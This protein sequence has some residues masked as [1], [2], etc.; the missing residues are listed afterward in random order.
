MIKSTP[1]QTQ[2]I[3]VAFMN[4]S[5]D[6]QDS[7]RDKFDHG[8]FFLDDL[9]IRNINEFRSKRHLKTEKQ[10]FPLVTPITLIA[11]DY[12]Y[13]ETEDNPDLKYI[14]MDS[15]SFLESKPTFE[16]IKTLNVLGGITCYPD[17]FIVVAELVEGGS[18][19]VKIIYRSA[20]FEYSRIEELL[21]L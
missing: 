20:S 13:D 9:T 15:I 17:F 3:I 11:A 7:E 6:H 2:N 18:Q 1:I 8:S 5:V 19:Y 14:L 21:R 16:N 4:Y 12:M 10:Y